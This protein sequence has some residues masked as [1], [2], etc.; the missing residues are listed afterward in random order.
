MNKSTSVDYP[1]QREHINAYL[2]R[3]AAKQPETIKA[4]TQLHKAA[5]SPGALE[6]KTKEL[7]ALAIAVA[8]RCDGFPTTP[9]MPL[10]P[11]PLRRRLWK[12]FRWRS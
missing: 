12:R 1:K 2:G 3:L 11:A 4:F 10:K 8:A 9:M 6:T 5:S 7:I